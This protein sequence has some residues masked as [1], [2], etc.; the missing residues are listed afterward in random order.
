MHKSC[1]MQTM[2]YYSLLKEMSYQALDRQGETLN[3]Y[4]YVKAANVKK[5]TYCM[6]RHNCETVK[7]SVDKKLVGEG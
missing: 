1:C 7:G 2:E 3:A 4:Y 5:A 6:K